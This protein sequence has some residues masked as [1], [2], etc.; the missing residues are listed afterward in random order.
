MS[1][2]DDPPSEQRTANMMVP[3]PEEHQHQH[4][5]QMPCSKLEA[6]YNGH[7]GSRIVVSSR[8]ARYLGVRLISFHFISSCAFL[9]LLPSAA[10]AAAP[11]AAGP[12][13]VHALRK[14]HERVRASLGKARRRRAPSSAAVDGVD[15]VDVRSWS[16]SQ[17]TGVEDYDSSKAWS[18]TDFEERFR[19]DEPA[20]SALPAPSSLPPI[21]SG[22]EAGSFPSLEEVVSRVGR[23]GDAMRCVACSFLVFVG[24]FSPPLLDEKRRGFLLCVPPSMAMA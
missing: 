12:S 7:T 10:P 3:P 9:F 21:P 6:Q 15:G 18:F 20:R 23:C 19:G 16:A 14:S 13:P 4:Q 22:I 1:I 24:H 11:A 17:L 8:R 5:H 2:C